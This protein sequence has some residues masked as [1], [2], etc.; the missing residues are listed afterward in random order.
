M[1]TTR[2]LLETPSA[3]IDSRVPG[4]RLLFVSAAALFTEV[5]LIRWIGTEVRIFAFVQNLSLIACFLGFGLGCYRAHERSSMLPTLQALTILVVMVSFPSRIWHLLLTSLSDFMSLSPDAALWNAFSIDAGGARA[6]GLFFAIV[7]VSY[8]IALLSKTMMPFGQWIAYY[9]DSAPNPLNAYTLNLLGSLAGTWLMAVVSFAKLPPYVWFILVFFLALISTSV[10]RRNAVIGLGLLAACMTFLF[11]GSR[12]GAIEVNWSPYQKIEV[13]ERGGGNYGIDVNNASYMTIANLTPKFL[14]EHPD[15]VAAY[16]TNSY[17]SPFQFAT[18]KAHVLIVGSGAGNDVA[19]ALRNGAEQVDAVEIDPVIYSVGRRLHPE[20]PYDSPKVHVQ[21]NDARNFMRESKKRYDVIVFALLDSHTGFSGYSNMRMDNY[22]YTEESFRSAQKL[23]TPNGLLVLKFEVRAPWTWMGQRFYT[24]L[25]Q[26]FG[27]A[28]V[29][30]YVPTAASLL[31]GTVFMESNSPTLWDRAQSPDTVTFLAAH[32]VDFPTTTVGA[33]VPTTDDWPF[34][35]HRARTIPQVYLIITVI[36]IVLAYF[37][38]RK[39]FR[40]R[41]ISTWH[42]LLLG[43]GFLLLETQMISRLALYFGSTWI[44]NCV[45]LSALL[46]VLVLANMF[47][48]RNGSLELGRYYLLLVISLL[49]VYALPWE[50]LP[51]AAK[52]IG[53]LLS[54]GFSIPVFFAGIIFAESFRCTS[55][56]SEALGAN[57][58]GAVSGG[59]LQNLSFLFGIKALILVAAG[60]Y[61]AAAVCDRTGTGTSNSTSRVPTPLPRG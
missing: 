16:K 15:F 31:S 13:T 29:A 59:A 9:M 22:V 49:C 37:S 36:L 26:I 38:V 4:I 19:A 1:E 12:S 6:V 18:S 45:A 48:G 46:S 58:F 10:S 28:P 53:I 23:L 60:I 51:F 52:T 2:A 14:A 34:V 30:Y 33:P 7:V 56:K 47:V 5:M 50:R 39:V 41:Q 24:M 32:P 27:R 40:P 43:G 25:H 20:H 44:V 35:Y 21:I 61:M 8:L 17:D 55:S 57:V 11:A 54:L 3:T 42:F